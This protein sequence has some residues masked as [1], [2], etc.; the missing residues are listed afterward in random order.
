[1]WQHTKN[2]KRYRYKLWLERKMNFQSAV[3]ILTNEYL[4]N[5]TKKLPKKS[6]KPLTKKK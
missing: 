4:T 6:K 3:N 2:L 5:V 1:M